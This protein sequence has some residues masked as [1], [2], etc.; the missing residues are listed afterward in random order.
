MTDRLLTPD[1]ANAMA[2]IESQAEDEA[3][4]RRARVLLLSDQGLAAREIASQAGISTRTV[5]RWRK[6]FVDRGLS[7]FPD[8][9]RAAAPAEEEEESGPVSPEPPGP[10][11]PLEQ[12]AKLAKKIK[13][14]G[15]QPDD[16]MA[17]AG[18]KV[19]RLHFA[20]MLYHEPGTRLGQD[21]E[22][23]H[24]MR[25]A[26]RRMRAAFEVFG[27][28]FKK[29]VL[30]AHLKGLR[31]TGRALGPVRDLDVFLQ[32]MQ[33]HMEGRSEEEQAGLAP[34]QS[35]WRAQRK[36]ARKKMLGYL[37]IQTYKDFLQSF[38]QFLNTPG[39][40]AKSLT[41]DFPLPHKVRDVAP[42]LIY[43]RL[44]AVR[45]FDS[46]LENATIDQ[47]HALRIEFKRLRYTVE[48]FQEV[49]GPEG[50]AVVEEIKKV[51][52]HLGDLNDADVACNILGDFLSKWEKEQLAL[53]IQKRANPEPIVAYLATK[54]AE[55]HRLVTTFPQVWERFM[56]PEFHDALAK[57]VSVL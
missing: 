7:S 33:L 41:R 8:G 44:G 52:D 24:D 55:R 27:D 25:V 34:L 9:G 13:T 15:I 28:Y 35:S 3:V 49:L 43:T 5:Y 57:A 18:R 32:K 4:Q 17:E 29:G 26:T 22:E 2:E 56:R 42:I 36:A 14:P 12:L 39:A 11:D 38:S 50:R 54:Y 19:L 10:S 40:G 30:K 31:A 21:I 20:R 46:V 6:A 53:S 47:L 45:A 51:Q 23:L 48:F 1:Q 16:S 37:D